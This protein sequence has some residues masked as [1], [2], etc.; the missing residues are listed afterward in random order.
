MF[1][2]FNVGA[3][4]GSEAFLLVTEDKSVLI[5]SGFRFCAREMTKNIKKI[6][7]KRPLDYIF[8]THSHYDHASGVPECKKIWKDVV[9]VAGEYAKK[10]LSKESAIAVIADMDFYAAKERGIEGY[11]CGFSEIPVDVTVRD[12][13][14]V[15]VGNLGFTAIATPG[16]TKCTVAYYCASEKLLIANETIGVRMGN[17]AMRPCFLV[18]YDMTIESIGK[19]AV[20]DVEKILIPH[21]GIE[22]VEDSRVLFGQ[23]VKDAEELKDFILNRHRKEK[24]VEEIVED[25]V[26]DMYVGETRRAQP[27][28]AFRLNA[29]IMTKLIIRELGDN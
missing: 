18:G 1:N 11:E 26:D 14:V 27:E 19:A 7:G 12:G 3:A 13:D 9:V 25:M 22:Y 10:I 21:H 8:L 5:D 24:S 20:L 17:S 15:K 6:L 28:K 4:R 23:A 29:E 16:H 2:L